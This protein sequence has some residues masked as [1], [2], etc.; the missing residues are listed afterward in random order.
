MGMNIGY[1]TSGRSEG[2]DEV[3]TPFYA[4]EPILEF[5]PKDKIIWCPFDEYWSAFVQLLKENGYKVIN[6]HI[7]DGIDFFK[8][9]PE[10]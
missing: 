5:L 4:V 2:S 7:K 9:Q 3:M 10:N 1:L 8:Q 6:S